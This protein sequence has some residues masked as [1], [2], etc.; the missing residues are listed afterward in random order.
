[1]YYLKWNEHLIKETSK[2]HQTNQN[3]VFKTIDCYRNIKDLLLIL[4]L[5]FINLLHKRVNT[6]NYIKMMKFGKLVDFG[7]EYNWLKPVLQE[8]R[9]GY[10]I[11]Q[12]M[13]FFFRE[14]EGGGV[15]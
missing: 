2:Q 12:K 7:K 11:K 15:D 9:N 13:Y 1:M 5:T 10:N 6:F 4:I 14:L 8:V 3:L